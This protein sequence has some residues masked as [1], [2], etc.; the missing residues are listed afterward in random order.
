M[1]AV[2][3]R[4][5]VDSPQKEKTHMSAMSTE[6]KVCL[7]SLSPERDGRGRG[8]HSELG[9]ASNTVF[10]KVILPP[11]ASTGEAVHVIGYLEFRS[12]VFFYFEFCVFYQILRTNRGDFEQSVASNLDSLEKVF[13]D[14]T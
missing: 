14:F 6:G 9:A 11:N 5:R 1:P 13:S 12:C 3:D 8:V 7:V 10:F 4:G 2:L